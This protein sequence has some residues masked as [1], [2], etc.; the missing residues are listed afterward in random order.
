MVIEIIEMITGEDDFVNF[1]NLS[2]LGKVVI[3]AA[4]KK[5]S[6]PNLSSELVQN[7]LNESPVKE[8]KETMTDRIPNLPKNLHW[9]EN[10]I[11][12]PF[13]DDRKDVMSAD[14]DVFP[15]YDGWL[16]ALPLPQSGGASSGF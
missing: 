11:V 3:F 8:Q 16:G 1:D 13:P 14:V 2:C 15:R 12:E 5:Q 7:I 4:I 9:A 6:N 10:A